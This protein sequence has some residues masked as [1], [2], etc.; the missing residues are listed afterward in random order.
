SQNSGLVSGTI[1]DWSNA[2]LIDESQERAWIG[3]VW[4][5]SCLSFIPPFPRPDGLASVRAYPNPFVPSLGHRIV[6]FA[7]LPEDAEVCIFGLGGELVWESGRGAVS[8]G[9]I[10]WSVVNSRGKEVAGGIYI[11][12]VRVAGGEVRTGRVAVV[13]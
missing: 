12:L 6:H 3:T 2:L 9:E 4:G 5:L 8:N 7:S 11:Y 13:R 1:G 10:S